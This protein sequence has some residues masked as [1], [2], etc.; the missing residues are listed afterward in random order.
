MIQY[1]V[2]KYE[3]LPEIYNESLLKKS[4]LTMKENIDVMKKLNIT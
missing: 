1:Q 2:F 4:E 3:N